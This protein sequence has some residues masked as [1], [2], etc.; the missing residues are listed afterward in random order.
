M[1]KV[2]II[3][4]KSLN[5]HSYNK[6]LEKI[7]GYKYFARCTVIELSVICLVILDSG[8]NNYGLACVHGSQ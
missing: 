2:E 6:L 3:K 1:V 7:Y 5:A 4:G 8:E